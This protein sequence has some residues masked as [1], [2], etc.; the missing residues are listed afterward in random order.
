[1]DK[2]YLLIELFLAP[3]LGGELLSGDLAEAVPS[4]FCLHLTNFEI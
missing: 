2:G 4:E 3:V 1:M